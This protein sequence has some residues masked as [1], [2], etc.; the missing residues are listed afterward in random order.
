MET[1]PNSRY[2]RSRRQTKRDRAEDDLFERL[3]HFDLDAAREDPVVDA[4]EDR[5]QEFIDTYGPR[6]QSDAW[7]QNGYLNAILPSCR[8]SAA[9]TLF[10]ARTALLSEE[11]ITGTIVQKSSQRRKRKDMMSSLRENTDVLVR[12]IKE[13]LS[14]D[15]DPCEKSLEW[16]GSSYVRWAEFS[17]QSFGWV[18]LDAI[19]EAIRQMEEDRASIRRSD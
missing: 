11:A 15:D 4:V 14:G 1:K 10:H 6:E 18:A 2:P 5:V 8:E 16:R 12:A 19:F 9:N 7:Q 13:E 17:G 3:T